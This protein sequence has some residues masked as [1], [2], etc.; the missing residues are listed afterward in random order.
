MAKTFAPCPQVEMSPATGPAID[1]DHLPLHTRPLVVSYDK[2]AQAMVVSVLEKGRFFNRTI[3]TPNSLWDLLV[4]FA[5]QHEVVYQRETGATW[6]WKPPA[7]V[8]SR[9][10]QQAFL[11]NRLNIS[12][13]D[14]DL[15]L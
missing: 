4:E 11:D 14:L 10:E 13:D 2:E 5:D 7:E 1:P 6:A 15:E 12:L 9:A 8:P 3:L